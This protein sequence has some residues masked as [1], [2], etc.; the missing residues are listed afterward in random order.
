MRLSESERRGVPVSQELTEKIGE[1][2]DAIHKDRQKELRAKLIAAIVTGVVGFTVFTVA[3]VLMI[4][5]EAP[6][7]AY[8]TLV[9]ALMKK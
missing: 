6:G 9:L 5:N 2:F 1:T 7:W 4:M 8:W 3:L